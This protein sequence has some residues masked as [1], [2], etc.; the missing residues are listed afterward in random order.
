MLP[1]AKIA[2]VRRLV[3]MPDYD[4][5]PLWDDNSGL[6]VRLSTLPISAS[7]EREKRELWIALREELGSDFQVGVPVP[8]PPPQTKLHV[9]WEPGGEPELPAWHKRT[10]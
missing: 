9:V 3:L 10:H 8:P 6:M 4:A 5:D 1:R 7:H 2:A